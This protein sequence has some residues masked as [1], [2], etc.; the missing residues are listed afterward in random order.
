MLPWRIP[1]QNLAMSPLH[2]VP[3]GPQPVP[4]C[5]I[6]GAGEASAKTAAIDMQANIVRMVSSY[7]GADRN[8]KKGRVMCESRPSKIDQRNL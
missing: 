3:T 2:C 8:S 7:A 6:D 5:A 4:L 1:L